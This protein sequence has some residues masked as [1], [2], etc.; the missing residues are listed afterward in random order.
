MALHQACEQMFG[1]RQPFDYLACPVCGA[2]QMARMPE[3][4]SAFYPPGYYSYQTGANARWRQILRRWRN[5]DL[6][7]G[8]WRSSAWQLLQPFDNLLALQGL[9]L[10]RQHRILDVGCGQG[11]LVL[12]LQEL[13]FKQV[14]GIDPFAE[15]SAHVRVLAIEHLAEG[16]WDLICFHHSLEHLPDPLAT[17]QVAVLRLAPRGRLLI[18]V[19]TVDSW[20]YR[21]YGPHWVQWDPPRHLYLFSRQNMQRFAELLDLRLVWLRDDSTGLQFWGSE[22]YRQGLPLQ[23]YRPLR[24]QR[25][26]ADWRA[27]ALNRVHQGDQFSCLLQKKS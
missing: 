11:Q 18:R 22:R 5:R 4:L 6:W 2:L 21:Y 23:G 24:G 25:L 17:L 10:Q 20:A 27:R 13:G 9:G 8:H 1:T 3:D 19:P 15:A 26:R 7:Q 16:N 12:A 14:L